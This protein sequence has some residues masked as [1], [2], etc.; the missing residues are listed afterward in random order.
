MYVAKFGPER[1]AQMQ[2]MLA[3]RGEPLDI[4]LCVPFLAILSN[5]NPVI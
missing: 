5:N 2:Q 4:F 3:Q 1:F